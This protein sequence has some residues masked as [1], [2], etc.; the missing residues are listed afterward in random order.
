MTARRVL[1]VGGGMSGTMAA[2]AAREAGAGVT[3]VM[4]GPGAS[5]LSNGVIE[6][7][8]PYMGEAAAALASNHPL[9]RVRSALSQTP[10]LPLR[11]A[12]SL[13][14][15]FDAPDEEPAESAVYATVIGTQRPG[16]MMQQ[17]QAPG[18]LERGRRYAIVSFPMQPA[19]VDADLVATSLIDAGFS[20]G[21]FRLDYLDR[22]DDAWRTVFDLAARLDGPREIERLA[23]S[24]Q[25]AV[26]PGTDTVLFPP[27]L[28]L[29]RSDV[30]TQLSK[31]VGLTCAELLPVVPSVPGLRLSRALSAARDAA[32]VSVVS[33][34]LTALRD[35]RAELKSGEVLSFDAAVLATGRF[36]GG[37]IMR[38]ARTTEGLAELP[39]SDGKNPLPDEAGSGAVAGD[40]V[41]GAAVLFRAGVEVDG[42]WRA[43]GAGRRP[44]PWLR[45]AGG[46]LA[47]V[48]GAVDG[49][50]I[51][52]A[53]FTGWLAGESAATRRDGATG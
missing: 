39:V 26:P 34:K 11:V 45:A 13:S 53:A 44:V 5:S 47:G 49:T 7:S 12:R 36:I 3:L 17:A 20:A 14:P 30:A 31:R 8:W 25:R 28:G 33:G 9:R 50:G 22:E 6:A 46:V 15:L 16:A 37:G 38:R 21:S 4:A 23:T 18:R 10:G 24:L 40:E 41:G 51:G 1:V 52:F 43:L 19:L 42:A 48:D 2:I 32:H 35:G 27:L 29:A